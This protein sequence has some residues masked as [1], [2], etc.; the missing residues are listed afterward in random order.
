MKRALL[1]AAA[2]GLC[3]V[4]CDSAQPVTHTTASPTAVVSCSS[5]SK[6]KVVGVSEQTAQRLAA[7]Q[8]RVV[9]AGN[10]VTFSSVCVTTLHDASP[11]VGPGV[12]ESLDA[13]VWN[14]RFRGLFG[15]VSCGPALMTPQPTCPPP[16]PLLQ[17][18]LDSRSAAFVEM[19]TPPE[20]AG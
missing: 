15:S 11:G 19:G 4:G 17:V 8:A 7:Q 20:L 12:G 5:P 10:S 13:L 1:L 16:Q 2:A 14:F 3:A 9:A 18:L 6:V